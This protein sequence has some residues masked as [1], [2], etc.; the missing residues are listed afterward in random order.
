VTQV[1]WSLLIRRNF[2]PGFLFI[3]LVLLAAWRFSVLQ[4]KVKEGTT[5]GRLAELRQA[6]A[7]YYQDHNGVFPRDLSLSGPFGRYLSNIPAVELL[8]PQH[9]LP[10]PGGRKITYGIDQP[11]EA[12]QGWYYNY[13]SGQI[14]VN[15]Q[16]LDTRG[17]PYS[18]Y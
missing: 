13:E 18:T 5:I 10:S 17:Q 14:F 9:R 1:N 2:L 8:H 4:E 7:L 6:I 11:E 3:L 12:G 15:S 16:G